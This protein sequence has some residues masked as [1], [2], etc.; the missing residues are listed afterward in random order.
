MK[1]TEQDIK[2][3]IKESV[4]RFLNEN[5]ESE[6]TPCVYVGTYGKYNNGS[7]EGEWVDLTQ[8]SSKQEFIDYCI[9]TLHANENDPEL[10]FQDY[11]YVPKCFIGESYIDERFWDFLNDDTYD[12]DIKYAV[13]DYYNDADDYFRA[14]DNMTVWYGCK[15]MTEVAYEWAEQVDPESLE[16]YFDYQSF[17]RDCSF[18]EPSDNGY[19]S[20]YQEYGVR[21]DDDYALGEAIV[22]MYGDIKELGADTIK[23]YVDYEKLGREL[24][25]DNTWIECDKG[26]IEIW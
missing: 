7:L 6:H 19:E 14:I 11:E 24:G 17:G 25:W 2:Q 4:V 13:A 22:D 18:D 5:T 1:I 10:M 12:Y 9:H 15:N 8:F 26:M 23:R 20:I 16:N 21:E 3:M